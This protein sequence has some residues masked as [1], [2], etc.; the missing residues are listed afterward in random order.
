MKQL[1]IFLI[2]FIS[3]NA[4]SVEIIK[5][6]DPPIKQSDFAKLEKTLYEKSPNL[7][8]LEISL[9]EHCDGKKFQSATIYYAPHVIDGRYKA[10]YR[11]GC[12]RNVNEGWNCSKPSLLANIWHKNRDIKLWGSI[13]R[14]EAIE[15]VQ[16]VESI[17]TN[18]F[19]KVFKFDLLVSEE[20]LPKYKDIHAISKRENSFNVSVWGG[21]HGNVLEVQRIEC[22]LEKCGFQIKNLIWQLH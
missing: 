9:V 15:I 5:C 3:S 19:D 11:V 12:S 16:F 18:S 13:S 17:E 14:N 20:E 2:I 7:Q 21:K 1:A 22:G 6:S 10:F 4:N 8:K